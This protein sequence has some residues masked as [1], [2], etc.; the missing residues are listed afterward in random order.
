MK[1]QVFINLQILSVKISYVTAYMGSIRIVTL[2]KV[3]GRSPISHI[4]LT[5]CIANFSSFGLLLSKDLEV[6]SKYVRICLM[7]L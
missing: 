1:S 7:H 5:F 2:K 6:F 4:L 3:K